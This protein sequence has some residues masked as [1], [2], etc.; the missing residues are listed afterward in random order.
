MVRA[1]CSESRV[2]VELSYEKMLETIIVG[3]EEGVALVGSEAWTYRRTF[4]LNA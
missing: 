4:K 1:G 2:K 3:V